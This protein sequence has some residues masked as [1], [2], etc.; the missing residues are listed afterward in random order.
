TWTFT[1]LD[2]ATLDIPID[3]AAGFLPQNRTAPDGEGFVSY[4]VRPRAGLTTGTRLDAQAS[5]VF[6]TNAEI[7][8]PA[9]FN[10]IDASAPSSR[11]TPLPART[12]SRSFTVS[13]SGQDEAGGS[14]I[15]S[16]DVFVSDNGGAFTPLLQGTTKT[17]TVFTGQ[18]GHTYGFFSVATDNVG[19]R[20]L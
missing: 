12:P 8:T 9:L 16:F 6:D 14:G 3:V 1:S 13:W 10:T 20:Q 15:A 18:V 5:I 17:S 7:D 19:H 2:P 11:L 4:T